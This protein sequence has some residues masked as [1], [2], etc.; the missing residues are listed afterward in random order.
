ME[1]AQADIHLE[2][3]LNISRRHSLQDRN[4]QFLGIDQQAWTGYRKAWRTLMFLSG[5]ASNAPY[6]ICLLT[7]S[8]RWLSSTLGYISGNEN[9]CSLKQIAT[10]SSSA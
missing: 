8:S 6:A 4:Y 1:S 9:D 5:Y 10:V 2:L 3:G 7:S